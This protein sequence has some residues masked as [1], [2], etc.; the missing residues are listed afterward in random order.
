MSQVRAPAAALYPDFIPQ[1][2]VDVQEESALSMARSMKRC[3]LD[4]PSM[5]QAVIQTAYVESK[6]KGET[7]K[8]FLSGVLLTQC[9]PLQYVEH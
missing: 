5:P 6:D 7:N 1:Q 2:I 3:M 9:S 8:H 4:I